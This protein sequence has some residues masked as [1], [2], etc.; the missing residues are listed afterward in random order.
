MDL[1]VPSSFLVEEAFLFL[2]EEIH[3]FL[4]EEDLLFPSS[5]LEEAFIFLVGGSLP[6]LEGAFHVREASFRGA[7]YLAAF[8][9]AFLGLEGHPFLE[10]NHGPLVVDRT[11]EDLMGFER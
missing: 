10:G 8:Q 6:F 11:S 9:V 2:V 3:P 5:F 4:V 1:L 7:S